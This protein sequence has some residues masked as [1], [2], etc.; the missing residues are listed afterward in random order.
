IFFQKTFQSLSQ[1]FVVLYHSNFFHLYSTSAL[2]IKLL[3]LA[4]DLNFLSSVYPILCFFQGKEKDSPET[5][6][7]NFRSW[8]RDCLFI[9]LYKLISGPV[10]LVIN[11][12]QLCL[13]LLRI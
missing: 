11:T 5:A 3:L 4:F 9:F 6:A 10:V 13:D 7:G 12:C 2:H 8:F 1:N